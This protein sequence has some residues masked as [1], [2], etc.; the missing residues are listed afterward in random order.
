MNTDQKQ[1][2][3]APKLQ[4]HVIQALKNVVGEEWVS[5]DRANL[6][7]YSRMSVDI[8]GT[9]K[10]HLKDSSSLPACIVLPQ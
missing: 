10:K 4:G 6:E 5:E 1:K 2:L 9:I 3:P 8:L 7:T